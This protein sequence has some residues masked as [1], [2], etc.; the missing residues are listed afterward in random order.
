MEGRSGNVANKDQRGTIALGNGGKKSTPENDRIQPL[1]L[2]VSDT[3]QA[4]N[5]HDRETIGD[6]TDNA[7]LRVLR[8][9]I[10]R[11]ERGVKR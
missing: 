6:P 8:S 1:D 11:S 7:S 10:R 4:N 9:E 5:Q 3:R 2:L